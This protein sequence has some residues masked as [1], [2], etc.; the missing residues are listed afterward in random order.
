MNNPQRKALMKM[1]TLVLSALLAVTA[2]QA[3][4]APASSK[5]ETDATKPNA[6]NRPARGGGF[7]GPITLNADDKPA[8]A[9]F[10][11]DLL[12]DVIP[13]IES[14]YAVRA[15]R[16]HRALAGLSMGGG[17]SLNF[18]L[19]HL[20]TFAWVG[21]FSPAPNTKP[22]AQLVP[23]PADA[24]EKLKLLWLSCGNKD[25]LIRVSQGVHVYL[26]EKN[27]PHIWHV[28]G[29]AHDSPE[30]RSNLYLFSQHLFR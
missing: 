22:P 21:A 5:A 1:F 6:A 17:Q 12:D 24:K 27:V 2:T 19:A 7:G 13:A 30:W 29:N 8:F 28:D 20:E 4:D 16:E 9:R 25:G 18:G 11:R 10:E 3:A 23:D 26:K 14:R 15:D